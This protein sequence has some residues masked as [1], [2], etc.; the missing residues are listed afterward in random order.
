LHDTVWIVNATTGVSTPVLVN[1]NGSF[2]GGVASALTDKVQIKITDPAGNETVIPIGLFRNSDGSVAVG[3]EGG[4]FTAGGGLIFDVPPGAFPHGAVVKVTALTEAEIHV[5]MTPDFPFVSGFELS[6]SVAPE[7][8]INVSAPPPPGAL[9]GD[10]GVVAEVVNVFGVQAYSIVDT[11]R[12]IGGQLKTS[13]PPC[14]GIVSRFARYAMFMNNNEQ[15]KNFGIALLNMMVIPR[16][17]SFVMQ[18]YVATTGERFARW[19]FCSCIF[20]PVFTPTYPMLGY[21]PT[22]A[23]NWR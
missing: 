9:E 1:A 17:Q 5:P 11:A 13:S 6:A 18:S 21:S 20:N 2:A 22:S 10:P 23:T 4:Q 15:M 14:P 7:K 3:P 16:T 8:Y 12:V 19:A